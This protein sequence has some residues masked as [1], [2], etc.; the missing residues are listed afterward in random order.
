MFTQVPNQKI[1]SA[2]I[3]KLVCSLAHNLRSYNLNSFESW[4]WIPRLFYMFR[5]PTPPPHPQASE[6]Q[7]DRQKK[8]EIDSGDDINS[9]LRERP[10]FHS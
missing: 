6:S 9:S 3:Q 4:R 10:L 5:T 1:K 2:V 8:E 7:V